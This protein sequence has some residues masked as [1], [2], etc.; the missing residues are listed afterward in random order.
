M[1]YLDKVLA[2]LNE[3]DARYIRGAKLEDPD[4]LAFYLAL[5]RQ[6]PIIR[7]ALERRI[8]EPDAYR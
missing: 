4:R 5:E 2:E 3:A 7:A 6:W 8:F 1:V